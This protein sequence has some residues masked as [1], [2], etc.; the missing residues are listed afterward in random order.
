MSASEQELDRRTDEA[1]RVL[2]PRVCAEEPSAATREQILRMVETAERA[3]EAVGAAAAERYGALKA[4]RLLT[5]VYGLAACVALLAGLVAYGQRKV[6]Q[7]ENELKSVRAEL[8]L[9]AGPAVPFDPATQELPRFVV[10][11]F[12][13]ERCPKAREMTPAFRELEEKF[14]QKSTV[15][16]TLDVSDTGHCEQSAAYAKLLGMG[17]VFERPPGDETG[18][19]K[20]VDTH[21]RQVVAEARQRNEVSQIEQMI[22]SA[23]GVPLYK[24]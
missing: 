8:S 13:H 9:A 5:A 12:Y 10:V 21:A 3:Q 16:I 2:I 7:L 20:L 17:F 11:N 1:L 22:A 24:R 4:N 14:C 23:S 19:L 15:F 18:V 6:G